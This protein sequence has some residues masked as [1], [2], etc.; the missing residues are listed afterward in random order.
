MLDKLRAA[1]NYFTGSATGNS[2]NM[3]RAGQKRTLWGAVGGAIVG[4]L[5]GSIGGPVGSVI[6]AFV[7]GLI[8]STFNFARSMI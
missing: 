2:R 1:I 8:G 7:G 3:V 6:G 4:I 5:L